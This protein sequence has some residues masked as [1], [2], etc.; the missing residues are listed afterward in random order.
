M[1]KKK[2]SWKPTRQG[3]AGL[4]KSGKPRG[5]NPRGV[6][7]TNRQKEEIYQIYLL[8]ANKSETA[9]RCSCATKTVAKVVK[10]FEEGTDPDFIRFRQKAI[11][12]MTG[13]VQN[14]T[15]QLIDAITPEDMASGRI[16]VTDD[17]GNVQRVIE[18]G[19][20]LM[21]KVTAMAIAV[22]K[23][24]VLREIE[25]GFEQATQ[26]D[27]LLLPQTFEALQS[28]IKSKLKS[29]TFLNVNFED[30]HKD[31]SQRVQDKLEEAQV[32]EE[33]EVLDLTDFDNP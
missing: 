30:E 28:G 25:G 11:Q 32:V 19:P 13:K 2:S 7:I 22:D 26:E 4:T 29:L 21:Q 18:Y 5:I 14:K 23:M 15:N 16:E 31:L 20:S 12:E 1:A 17:N 10:E 24:K 27:A 6:Q 3:E 9:R 33:A 8:T